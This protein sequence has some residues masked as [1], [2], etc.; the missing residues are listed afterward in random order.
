MLEVE[1]HH[2]R[3]RNLGMILDSLPGRA[4]SSPPD[5][6]PS[7][8]ALFF[9]N[10]F[11]SLR[12]QLESRFISSRF[13]NSR[14]SF[15]YVCISFCI[16]S[17]M[18]DRHSKFPLLFLSPTFCLTAVHFVRLGRVITSHRTL[19]LLLCFLTLEVVFSPL[20]HRPPH[21]LLFSLLTP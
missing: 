18:G 16:T 2:F 1:N 14:L 8:A 10:S 11:P 17:I 4:L 15:S 9:Q 3:A 5:G 21:P 13:S 6:M 7:I 20:G 12:P 19:P